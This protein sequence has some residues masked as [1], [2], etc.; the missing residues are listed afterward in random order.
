MSTESTMTELAWYELGLRLTQ[1]RIVFSYDPDETMVANTFYPSTLDRLLT[2]VLLL[3]DIEGDENPWEEE[4]ADLRQNCRRCREITTEEATVQT[5][6]CVRSFLK[7]LMDRVELWKR[8]LKALHLQWFLLGIEI[9][10]GS[11]EV[12]AD[13]T[14]DAVEPVDDGPRERGGSIWPQ[15]KF[16]LNPK[17]NWVLARENLN[18]ELLTSLSRDME[19]VFPT[20]DG[21][22][23]VS[24]FTTGDF[25]QH[26]VGWE[27][28]ELGLITMRQSVHIADTQLPHWDADQKT[29]WVGNSVAKRYK[30]IASN[31]FAVFEEFERLGWPQKIYCPSLN[32]SQYD[33]TIR[34]IN[35]RMNPNLICFSG[36]GSSMFCQKLGPEALA[37][38]ESANSG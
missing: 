5:V 13:D 19:A 33:D 31:Q 16:P 17:T 20:L 2:A 27:Q 24:V 23:D 1:A 8:R 15:S 14:R 6:H 26:S 11:E 21:N 37:E 3:P 18:H 29:L 10:D 34:A 12:Q 9:A 32:S 28:I 38:T 36:Y 30:R 25:L 4:V 35:Q 22:P 7:C